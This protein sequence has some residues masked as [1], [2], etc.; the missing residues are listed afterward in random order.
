MS[1]IPDVCHWD[2]ECVTNSVALILMQLLKGFVPRD[3]AGNSAFRNLV[4][5]TDD[6][7]TLTLSDYYSVIKGLD[8]ASIKDGVAKVVSLIDLGDV[9]GLIQLLINMDLEP[10]IITVDENVSINIKG[11]LGARVNEALGIALY[12]IAAYDNAITRFSAAAAIYEG[13]GNVSKARF[14]EAMSKIARAEDLRVKASRLHEEGKHDAEKDMIED[15]SKLYAS[16]VV[17]FREAVGIEE[18]R[19]MRC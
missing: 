6:K 19:L 2:H 3:L 14:M 9:P 8:D 17:S 4:S 18:A 7:C 16:S 13:L 12:S 10:G 15:A 1:T 5:C 11:E